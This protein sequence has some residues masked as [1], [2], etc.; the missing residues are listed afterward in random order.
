MK[1]L[2]VLRE[3]FDEKILKIIDLFLE[4]QDVHFSLTQVSEESGVSVA[5]SLRILDKLVSKGVVEVNLMGKS[6]FYKLKLGEKTVELGRI[7]KREEHLS[8]A[9]EKLK[10]LEEVEKIVLEVKSDE[11]A[12]IIL[13]GKELPTDLIDKI[14]SE[15][16]EKYGF[17]IF[18]VEISPKQFESMEKMNIYNLNKKIIWEKS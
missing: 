18:H 1:Q 7:L 9:I 6:K 8:E 17:K 4:K 15:I 3:L 2:N 11:D 16:N 12:K 5:T 10:A 14:T 13:V